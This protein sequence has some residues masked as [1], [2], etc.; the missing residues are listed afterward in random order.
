MPIVSSGGLGKSLTAKNKMNSNSLFRDHA[1][2]ALLG[3]C[4]TITICLTGC[5]TFSS[6][7]NKSVPVT[8]NMT[9]TTDQ[10]RVE[11]TIPYQKTKIYT[12]TIDGPITVQ[13]AL[14]R[15]G[16]TERYRNMDVMVLRVVKETGRGLKMPVDFQPRTKSVSSQ[17]DYAIHPGDRIVVEPTSNNLLDQF[18]DAVAGQN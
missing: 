3:V 17:Q 9:S 15:S 7:G 8:E 12:G 4:L 14:E 16:A 13:T 11:M 1:R 6:F 18:M 10:Y 5:S 2:F